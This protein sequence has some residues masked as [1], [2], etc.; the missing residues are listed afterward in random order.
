[1]SEVEQASSKLAASSGKRSDIVVVSRFNFG[2][3]GGRGRRE[4]LQV[5]PSKRR[6][7][8]HE[9]QPPDLAGRAAEYRKAI[10][11]EQLTA[12]VDS[13]SHRSTSTPEQQ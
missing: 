1:M 3:L 11:L 8:A 13:S 7:Q 2:Q 4:L 5:Y 10:A 12:N 9:T 6:L